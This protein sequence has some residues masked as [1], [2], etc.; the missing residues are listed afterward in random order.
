VAN[1]SHS[2]AAAG[3]YD[4]QLTVTDDGGATNTIIKRVTVVNND[5][6]MMYINSVTSANSKVGRSKWDAEVTITVHDNGSGTNL[7]EGA[8]VTGVWSDG[9]TGVADSCTTVGGV[10]SVVLANISK[11][12][13]SVTFTITGVTHPVL[14]YDGS[15]LPPPEIVSGPF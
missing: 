3:A 10:C 9:A 4:V 14:V 6:T 7:V 5:A 8:V 11:R 12:T 2:F 13:S 1:P 15:P